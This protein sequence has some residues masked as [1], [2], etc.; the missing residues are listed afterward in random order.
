MSVFSAVTVKVPEGRNYFCLVY[1]CATIVSSWVW[2]TY[3]TLCC[4]HEQVTGQMDHYGLQGDFSSV[5]SCR[6]TEISIRTHEECW[7][8]FRCCWNLV[9]SLE[10]GN[11]QQK[12][13]HYSLLIYIFCSYHNI[14]LLPI[15]LRFIRILK[16]FWKTT[17]HSSQYLININ[18]GQKGHDG[19]NSFEI[20]GNFPYC[21]SVTGGLGFICFVER[22]VNLSLTLLHFLNRRM[23]SVQWWNLWINSE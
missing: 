15:F 16:A 22:R 19:H 14:S 6:F 21:F 12:Q 8:H 3:L 20:T 18:L 7:T 2:P 9:S 17:E 1:H 11:N 13:F 23:C 4:I 10:F 5:S